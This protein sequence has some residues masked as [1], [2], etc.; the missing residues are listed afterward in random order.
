MLFNSI[1]FLLFLPVVLG[2][3]RAL[4]RGRRWILLVASYVFYGFWDA[5][6]L[7]LIVLST[8]I[9]YAVGRALMQTEDAGRRKAW[10]GLSILA[11]L[12]ILSLFKYADFFIA[13]ARTFFG[14]QGDWALDLI[15]PVGISFYTFQTLGYT[16]DVYRHRIP[17]ERNLLTFA[18]F[19]AFFPQLMAGPIERARDLL[20]QLRTPGPSD[21]A[22]GFRLFL[23][24]LVKKTFISTTLAAHCDLLYLNPALRSPAE[25]WWMGLLMF[26]HI[27][28]DFSG[29]SD[30]ALGLGRMFGI[31][32]SPNFNNVLSSRSFL[33]FWRR[34]HMTLGR[35]FRD[36]VLLPLHRAGVPRPAAY[37]LTFS[38]IG[39]WHGASWNFVIWGALMGALWLLDSWRTRTPFPF[40][41][42]SPFQL[43]TLLSFIFIGQFFPTSTPSDALALM[44]S[45]VGWGPDAPL[46]FVPVPM[47]VWL[48]LSLGLMLEWAVPRWAV[49]SEAKPGTTLWIR[50]LIL[51]PAG[52]ALALESLNV[53]REFVYFQF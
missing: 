49:W 4:P 28:M 11:N 33:E 39:L 51:V 6:F 52:L 37:L 25:A 22:G 23:L 53:A 43:S 29:Y 24:G 41:F 40:Q 46:P 44:S 9:D 21:L 47:A 1:D 8:A 16:L 17:A 45:M 14:L 31:R 2:L 13:E 19:V 3:Y 20:P 35:W 5:Q 38:L 48:A 30:M 26:M 10:L 32:L 36:Y 7:G 15:L 42:P 18:V 50:S 12:S 34:W 27:L